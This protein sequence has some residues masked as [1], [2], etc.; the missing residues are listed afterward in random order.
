VRPSEHGANAS[1]A[2]L[3]YAVLETCPTE[4]EFDG[5]SKGFEGATSIRGADGELYVLGLCEGNHCK[6][7]ALG[8]D[9]GNG[10]V[11]VMKRE[12]AAGDGSFACVWKTV[13]TISLPEE[14][15]FVDYSALSLHHATKA[16]AV[17]SQE[18]SQLWISSLSTA[19][20]GEFEPMS[21]E[22]VAG[23]KV[24][25]FPRDGAC[26]P[27]YCNIEG[28]H[29]L[30]GGGKGAPQVLAAV[31]DKMKSKGRQDF[32]C[33]PKDQSVHIFTVP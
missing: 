29:W 27:Q 33:L 1:S 18:N 17:T 30:E 19:S 23:G 25:D 9:A 6:E 12:D 5:D 4:I 24:Y 13:R 3:D 26:E 15:A 7:D 16:V 14:V 2:T 10:R 31:S 20:D 32:R 21:A 28:I 8:K 22:F 11:V